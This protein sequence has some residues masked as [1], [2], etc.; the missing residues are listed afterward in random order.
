MKINFALIMVLTSLLA[1]FVFAKESPPKDL[2]L[3]QQYLTGDWNGLRSRLIDQGITF[4]LEYTS[5]YQ[6]LL[7][8]TKQ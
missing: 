1:P 2:I 7:S 4:D 5:T 6:G 3:T 8:G